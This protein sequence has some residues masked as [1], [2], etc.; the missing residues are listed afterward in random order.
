MLS[1][2]RRRR[3]YMTSSLL[4]PRPCRIL[5]LAAQL[6]LFVLVLPVILAAQNRL[7]RFE[8]G[9]CPFPP[10]EWARDVRLE[11]GRLV[12]PE[13]RAHPEGRTLRLAVAI[14]RAKE[15]SGAPPLVMLHGGPA[16]FGGLRLFTPL[17]A[18]WPLARH[19]DI[20][21]YDLRGAGLS[22]P[23]LCPE[24][25]EDAGRAL[26]DRSPEHRRERYLASVRT[27]RAWLKAQGIDPAA[28]NT[29]TNIADLIDL[30]RVL[31]YASW[32]VYGVSYGA[33]LAQEA[34]RRDLH[35]IRSAVLQNPPVLG[36][37]Y[38]AEHPLFLQRT[39]EHVFAA[40]AAQPL[41]HT[42]FPSL[43][44][45]FYAVYDEVSKRPLEI[46][47]ERSV[48]PTDTVW[49]DDDRLLEN[50]R[51]QLDSPQEIARLP[52]LLH[53]L[54][55]GDR[56]RAARV[57]VGSGALSPWQV[58]GHL[59]FCYDYDPAYPTA[60][61]S[62]RA[63]VRPPFR[64]HA[65][66]DLRWDCKLWQDRFAD[67]SEHAPVQSDI[68]TLLLTGEFDWNT[69]TEGARRIAATLKRSYLY[70]IPGER[71][72]Q[73]P[74][75]CHESILLQFLENPTRQPDASCIATV[76]RIAFE[77]KTL[78][79]VTLAFV[80]TAANEAQTV[81]A[82][83]WEAEFPHAPEMYTVDLQ[84]DGTNLTG[85]IATPTQKVQ[86]YEG[87]IDGD[88][89][90]FKIKSPDGQRMI[91]FTGKVAGDEITFT[92]DVEVRAGGNPGGPGIFGA[93]GARTFA[94]KRAK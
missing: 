89:M 72:G 61:A 81:F 13:V 21:I 43:E 60:A 68:P 20:V 6:L 34:M 8:P 62:V 2:G 51:E 26:N 31:G 87:M 46:Q 55:R 59:V 70:E 19:R 27:C 44:E 37:A 93:L 94:A 15:P 12:V 56:M 10:G 39:L 88:T 74:E 84:T 71:H 14:L 47:V 17:A 4:L 83:R 85:T 22:E 82:G 28:Y 54:R 36:P 40:C 52:L 79:I 53:E 65:L 57:L 32:D 78:D 69:P 67:P 86:I 11:C 18:R 38:E 45:D 41:C 33:L 3:E 91:T 63:K 1:G 76:P 90:T 24:F 77:T 7:P 29:A 23:K 42:A 9:E 50:I 30:R 49:L 48:S 75:G 66:D 35:G 92:R 25:Y 80:I 73:R 16:G 5:G 64:T 58:L